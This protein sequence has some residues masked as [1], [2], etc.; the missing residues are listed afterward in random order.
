MNGNRH[1]SIKLISVVY[2]VFSRQISA[3]H[4]AKSIYQSKRAAPQRALSWQSQTEEGKMLQL[5]EM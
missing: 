4:V 5:N 1:Y 2:D 3:A